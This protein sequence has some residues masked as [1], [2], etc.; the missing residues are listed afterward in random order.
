M[1]IQSCAA[2]HPSAASL[3]ITSTHGQ[4]ELSMVNCCCSDLHSGQCEMDTQ[5]PT[6]P[7]YS[8]INFWVAARTGDVRAAVKASAKVENNATKC[9]YSTTLSFWDTSLEC[10]HR[11]M[12][13]FNR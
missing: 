10:F 9:I 7:I 2:L 11:Q 8:I 1:C 5:C 3:L 6:P 4:G 12:F 13:S